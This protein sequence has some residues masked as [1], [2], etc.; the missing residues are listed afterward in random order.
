MNYDK[1]GSPNSYTYMSHKKIYLNCNKCSHE[2]T[3]IISN[4][5]Y[6]NKELVCS[7]CNSLETWCINNNRYDILDRWDYNLNKFKP[8]D[9]TYASHKKIYLLCSNRKHKSELYRIS[10]LEYY[11]TIDS[12]NSFSLDCRKCNSFAQ[13]NIDRY[14]NDFLDK[15]WD[16]SLNNLNPWY[17][18][19]CGLDI[20]F[21][22]CINNKLHGSYKIQTSS[23][24]RLNN[25]DCPYCNGTLLH[26][27]NSLGYVYPTVIDIW[28][29]K[30]N[31]T[32]LDYIYHNNDI[33]LWWKCENGVHEDYQR[34]I[35]NS[36]GVEFRCPNCSSERAESLLQEK[37][38][39]YL[40][41]LGYNINHEYLCSIAPIHPITKRKLPYDN[42]I[43]INL[44]N[45]IIEVHGLQHYQR[46][47]N[48]IYKD[49]NPD[50]S[51]IER[52]WRDLYKKEYALSN[53][54]YYLEIPYTSEI[55]DEYKKLIDN[56]ILEIISDKK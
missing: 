12:L 21:I 11:N 6:S 7:K 39:K 23:F 15:Y 27:T 41:N 31:S 17:I 42:E 52:K 1:N 16:Y 47:K 5:S 49:M 18:S 53:G 33:L 43:I 28:S 14:G 32:P 8:S 55:N 38:R 40:I 10:N 9:I 35:G 46:V 19:R 3:Y 48:W 36:R 45:L 50:E 2:N 24:G 37:V 30:N 34:T 20:I 44:K 54:Y 4:I 56:K 29:N 22:K 51:L 13:F 26:F 25:I